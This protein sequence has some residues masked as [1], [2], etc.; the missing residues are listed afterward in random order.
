MLLTVSVAAAAL[1]GVLTLAALPGDLRIRGW[2]QETAGKPAVAQDT[3]ANFNGFAISREGDPRVRWVALETSVVSPL[4]ADGDVAWLAVVERLE[5]DGR[6]VS[7]VYRVEPATGRVLRVAELSGTATAATLVKP[8]AAAFAHGE[9][10]TLVSKDGKVT[11]VPTLAHAPVAGAEGA[12][13]TGLA[14][15]NGR[16]Y[17]VSETSQQVQE[18]DPATRATRVLPLPADVAPPASIAATPGG[19]LVLSTPYRVGDLDPAS[20]LMDPATGEVTRLALPDVYAVA[21]GTDG[22]IVATLN[23]P[24]GGMASLEPGADNATERATSIP[25][26]GKLDLLAVAQGHGLWGAPYQ[27]GAVYFER[28]G[29][30][31]VTFALPAYRVTTSVPRGSQAPGVTDVEVTISSMVVLGDGTLVFVGTSPGGSAG[32]MRLP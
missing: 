25:W 27:G 5:D 28:D 21:V 32:W 7:A 22:R 12:A 18:I 2:W 10:I 30:E 24:G 20:A 23:R 3:P 26:T 13:V 17:A 31:L 14:A 1:A 4:V 29:G 16:I 11:E 8:G 19:R 15:H 9:Q 6:P